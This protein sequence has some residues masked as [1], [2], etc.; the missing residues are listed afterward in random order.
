M[1]QNTNLSLN[2]SIIVNCPCKI[3]DNNAYPCMILWQLGLFAM[4]EIPNSL[5]DIDSFSHYE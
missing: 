4:E 1:L 3:M 2:K 5:K